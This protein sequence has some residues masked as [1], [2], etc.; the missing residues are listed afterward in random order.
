MNEKEVRFKKLTPHEG[1]LLTQSA[2]VSILER[3]FTPSVTMDIDEQS[4]LWREITIAEAEAL[5]AEQSEEIRRIS[6]AQ[7]KERRR[8]ELEAELKALDDEQQG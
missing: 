8:A 3:I 4:S 5:R 6:V 1:Y 2:E 7:E